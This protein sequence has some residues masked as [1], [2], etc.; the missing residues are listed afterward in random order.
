[1]ALFYHIDVVDEDNMSVCPPD[2]NGNARGSIPPAPFG[3]YPKLIPEAE[4]NVKHSNKLSSQSLA[5]MLGLEGG[6]QSTPWLTGA[7]GSPHFALDF[8][9]SSGRQ[10]SSA[11]TSDAWAAFLS[12]P[13]DPP[14]IDSARLFSS[15]N[16]AD[17]VRVQ[18]DIRGLSLNVI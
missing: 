11:N 14:P 12:Q 3:P 6:T 1:M 17:L 4:E 18:V 8:V 10:Q 15:V 5:E 16:P 2:E 7:V 9:Q 13:D